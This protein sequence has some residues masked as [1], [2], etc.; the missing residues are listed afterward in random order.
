MNF[1]LSTRAQDE[2]YDYCGL[3]EVHHLG[4]YID[5]HVPEVDEPKLY[6]LLGTAKEQVKE[7]TGNLLG[8][9][10]IRARNGRAVLRI[11]RPFLIDHLFK[12]EELINT[13]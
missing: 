3:A 2:V 13:D 4:D 10:F 12:I 1:A 9:Q 6:R 5:F 8:L 7:E 11:R